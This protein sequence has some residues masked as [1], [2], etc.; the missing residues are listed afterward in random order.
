MRTVL[1]ARA[2]K[3]RRVAPR[4][5]VSRFAAL[6]RQRRYSTRGLE[7]IV[8]EIGLG[9][10]PGDVDWLGRRRIFTADD[11]MGVWVSQ[12]DLVTTNGPQASALRLW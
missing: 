10:R 5:N 12:D 2:G 3:H 11:D 4:T 8:L 1:A 9:S 7:P 6:R